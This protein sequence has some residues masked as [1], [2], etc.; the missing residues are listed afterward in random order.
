[1]VLAVLLGCSEDLVCAPTMGLVGLGIGAVGI[2]SALTAST[3][4][5]SSCWVDPHLQM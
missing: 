3:E 1:M 2:L 5:P 4:H